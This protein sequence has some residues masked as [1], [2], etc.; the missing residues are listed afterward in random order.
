M[1]VAPIKRERLLF[2][3]QIRTDLININAYRQS[4]DIHEVQLVATPEKLKIR[5]AV[6]LDFI[7]IEQ[8]SA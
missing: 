4:L 2:F 3:R 5:I 8:T 7:T 1:S 6:L